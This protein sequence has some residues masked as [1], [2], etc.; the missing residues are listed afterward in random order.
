MDFIGELSGCILATVVVV[1]YLTIMDNKYK[2]KKVTP[3]HKHQVIRECNP[4][5]T[6]KIVK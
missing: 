3:K 4:A 6:F 5:V 2:T 1:G